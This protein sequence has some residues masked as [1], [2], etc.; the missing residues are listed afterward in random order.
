MKNDNIF[1]IYHRKVSNII[2]K[3]FTKSDRE[4]EIIEKLYE[5]EVK[6]FFNC[7]TLKQ[8]KMH[9]KICPKEILKIKEDLINELKTI[10]EEKFLK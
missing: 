8:Y 1:E 7:S 5:I 2:D 6:W 9:A 4:Y 3:H 10:K